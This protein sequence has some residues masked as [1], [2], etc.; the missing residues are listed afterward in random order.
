M[1]IDQVDTDASAKPADVDGSR[2]GQE[3]WVAPRLATSP[4][5]EAWSE[6]TIGGALLRRQFVFVPSPDP[7]EHV[8]AAQRAMEAGAPRVLR[9][10]PGIPGHRF[11]LVD[12]VLEPL[13]AICE[14]EGYA[15]ALDWGPSG[16]LPLA[17]LASFACS[18]P[19]VPLL[20]LG[21]RLFEQTAI[22]RLLDR[23]P[24]ILLQITNR[25]GPVDLATGIETFGAHRFVYGSRGAGSCA[26]ET[27]LAALEVDDKAALLNGNARQLDSLGWREQWL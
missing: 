3:V 14:R 27:L 2:S 6:T 25:A 22:W 5:D 16:A 7:W 23:C 18:A 20:L 4:T 26:D 24:N 21:D 13:P 1:T 11:P 12:W 9:L 8:H 15:L 17:E 19:E 10:R